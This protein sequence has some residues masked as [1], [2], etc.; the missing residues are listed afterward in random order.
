MLELPARRI[1]RAIADAAERWADAD[2]P[3]RVRATD[4]ICTRTGYSV[5]VVDYALDRLFFPLTAGALEA[6][7]AAEL[8]SLDALD[9]F[10]S[11][12]GKAD[13]YARG[14][15]SVCVISSRTTIGVALVPALYALCAK[16]DVT[17]KDREDAFVAAFFET[18][19]EEHDAF[20]RAARAHQWSGDSSPVDL[21]AFDAVV[22]F[23][24]NSTLA[25]IRN[26]CAPE[27]RF[28]PFGNRASAGYVTADSLQS[29][30]AAAIARGAARDF[31]LYDTEGCL[32]LHVLFLEARDG[33]P[34]G[35][36]LDQLA[37]AARDAAIEFPRGT[38]DAVAIAAASSLRNAA[39]FRAAS[40]KGAVYSDDACSFVL[41]YDPPADEPPSFAPRTLAVVP[42]TGPDDAV[43]YLSNHGIA[44]E[45]F[46]VSE[47]R[48]DI[49]GAAVG[50]GAV[51]LAPFGELQR[52]PL[53]AD[54]GGRPR[55]ADFIRWIDREI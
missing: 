41:A 4:A 3:P 37:A 43:R 52:L 13:G 9:G 55:I 28:I 36:F 49:A 44:V 35:P 12:T 27:A 47:R 20:A 25:Q 18:L 38:S 11:R 10:V 48:D 54:H 39:A 8:G 19:A 6:T 31:L 15:D 26:L 5:P 34:P 42:V 2:F 33:V 24:K 53:S 22:A 46:A 45:A 30:E 32:S 17:V 40:G 51:R 23:G 1:V 21:T 14:V 16:C 29:P 50:A 7:I